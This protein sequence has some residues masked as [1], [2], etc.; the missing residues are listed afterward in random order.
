MGKPRMF[1]DNLPFHGLKLGFSVEVEPPWAVHSQSVASG[2]QDVADWE[3]LGLI[4]SPSLLCTTHLEPC[5]VQ[6]PKC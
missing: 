4:L 6:S 1:Y 2:Q 5:L 3:P